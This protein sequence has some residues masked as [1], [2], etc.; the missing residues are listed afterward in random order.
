MYISI[1]L[2]N[3]MQ[4]CTKLKVMAEKNTMYKS[5]LSIV[6]KWMANI[7]LNKYKTYQQMHSYLY[8]VIRS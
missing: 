3:M 8:C 1:D 7:S 6:G 5:R 4:R 2:P